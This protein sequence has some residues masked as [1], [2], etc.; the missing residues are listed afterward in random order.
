MARRLKGLLI[1]ASPAVCVAI[2]TAA[3][4][5]SV[6]ATYHV[7]TA[8]SDSNPGTLA[9]PF[10]TIQQAVNVVTPGDTIL[11]H[12]GTYTQKVIITRSGSA[13]KFITLR[14]AEDPDVIPVTIQATFPPSDCSATAP[15]Y[16]RTISIVNGADYWI[17]RDFRIE[18]GILIFGSRTDEEMA[19]YVRDRTLPGR[20]TYDPAAARTTLGQ[21][22]SNGADYI[23]IIGNDISGMG[24]YGSQTRYGLLQDNVVHHTVC[25]TG[26]AIWLTTFSD[27]WRIRTNYVHHTDY[28]APSTYHW[29]SEGI[30][31]GRASMYNVIEKNVVEDLGGTGRGINMDVLAGWNVIRRNTVRRAFQGLA[32]QAGGGWGNQWLY[33]RTESSG[34][35]GFMVAGILA[36]VSYADS[37]VPRWVKMQCNESVNEPLA[38][39]IGA[40]RQATFAKNKF[41]KVNVSP[42]ARTEWAAAQ[43]KW[44]GQATP[45]PQFPSTAGF[46]NC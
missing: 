27:K 3:G 33:N 16:D 8:G 46:A 10:R 13:G 19:P 24:V 22:G 1:L 29:Q 9:L 28:A 39:A 6:G 43:N 35:V 4:F 38:L 44:N 20:G 12:P 18:G 45:P 15:F 30:R 32:E 31:L 37:A 2:W 26:S 21:L 7:S 14:P 40:V 5:S 25:G 41:P 34:K 36:T 42:R 17:I 23:R 11:V